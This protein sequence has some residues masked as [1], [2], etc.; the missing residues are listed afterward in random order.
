MTPADI[1]TQARYILND[2]DSTAYRQSDAELLSY[3][4]DALGEA[5][6]LAPQLFYATY[7][8][9]CVAG[10]EQKL[11]FANCQVLVDV[12]RIKNGASIFKA[13]MDTLAAFNPNWGSVQAG[14]AMHWFRHA[15]DP[16]GFYLYPAA[17]AGQVIEVKYVRNPNIVALTDTITDLST[18][19]LSALVWAVVAKAEMKDDEHVD[20]GRAV[21]AY[22]QFVAMLKTPGA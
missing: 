1:I 5:A 6:M 22:N 7:D 13:D 17:I 20:S 15:M 4:N 19:L 14:P 16:L 18:T 2:T 10:T 21:S 3:V 8:F 9:T 11:T 12:V